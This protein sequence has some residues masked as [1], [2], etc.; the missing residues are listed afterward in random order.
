MEQIDQKKFF[1][2]LGGFEKYEFEYPCG[3][4]VCYRGPDGFFYRIDR[5]GDWYVVEDAE[6]E[7]EAR[8]N[9]FEDTDLFDAD[10]DEAELVR[11]IQAWF[12]KYAYSCQS[13]SSNPEA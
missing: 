1:A 7:E 3:K 13:D 11:Q 8:V 6:N 12:H 4:Y 2:G 9:R 5:F 10:L